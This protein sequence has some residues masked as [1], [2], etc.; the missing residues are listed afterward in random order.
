MKVSNSIK[1]EVSGKKTDSFNEERINFALEE[2][3]RSRQVAILEAPRNGNVC[4]SQFPSHTGSSA[5]KFSMWL[6][7]RE[8][9]FMGGGIDLIVDLQCG[10]IFHLFALISSGELFIS[11]CVPVE[12]VGEA[13]F[14]RSLKQIS[15]FNDSI[16]SCQDKGF[17]SIKLSVYQAPMPRA[18]S[19]QSS[20]KNGEKFG[21]ENFVESFKN[22]EKFG[23]EYFVGG[24]YLGGNS[25]TLEVGS[26]ASHSEIIKEN[27]NFES[28][29][30]TPGDSCESPW[31]LMVVYATHLMS[32]PSSQE[33]VGTLSPEV[34]KAVYTAIQ[35]AGDQGLAIREVSRVTNTLGIH[36][37]FY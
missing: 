27:L 16:D 24:N 10:E 19:L 20:F 35:K 12:G 37:N 25:A 2:V 32:L 15:L 6:R 11:P 17:P 7:E 5:A 30:P 8:N 21:D 34:F 26:N 23:N 29:V 31:E 13:E 22:G 4:D 3:L 33:H 28:T 18:I 36:A 9:D 1:T 14:I